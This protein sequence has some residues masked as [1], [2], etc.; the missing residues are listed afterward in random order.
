[1]LTNLLGE[2]GAPGEA[3]R[4]IVA[5]AGG[6]PLFIEEMLRMLVD[7][8]HLVRE[9]EAWVVRGDL[10]H[11]GAP[12]T[13][14]AVIAARLDRLDP[15]ERAVLQ[16]ASVVG[17]VFWWGAV[18]DLSDQ[19][20]A[21]QV[22]RSLQALVRKEL[23]RPGPSTFAG[24]DAFRFGHL[25]IR[26]V[27][28]ESIPK[29]VRADLHARFAAWVEQRAGERAVEYEEI[30]GYHAEQ[31]H[32][33]LSELGPLDDRGA[34]LAVLA[35]ERLASAGRRSF[36]RGDM[37]AAG[38]LLARAASLLPPLHQT[39]LALLH[40]LAVALEETGPLERAEATLTEALESGRAAGDKSL[41]L[42]AATRLIYVWL[43][44]SPA[45]THEKALAELDSIIAKL[46]E[47]RDDRATAEALLVLGIV[48]FWGGRC[49]EALRTFQRA[50]EHAGRVGDRRSERELKHWMGLTLVQGLTPAEEA[51][52]RIRELLRGF[53]D[54][55]IFRG[56]NCRFLS[57]LEG[58]QGN[59]SKAWSL[60][61][62][63]MEIARELGL[64]REAGGLQ[65]SGGYVALLSGDLQRAEEE[66][67]SAVAT[68]K[69]IGDT[70]HLVSA[71][72]DLGLVLLES[73][74]RELEAMSMAK[75][76]EEWLIEDD[77]DAQVRW[78]AVK[79]RALVRLGEADEAERLARHA[80]AIAGAT[81]YWNLRAISHEAMAEVLHRTG[82]TSEAAE[83][84]RNAIAVYEEKRNLVSAASARNALAE[85]TAGTNAPQA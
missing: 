39:R 74:G 63:G 12:E 69:Q 47:L 32:R 68:L 46:E 33:Y 52:I 35:G 70:G 7:D 11:I 77:V 31:A 38:H 24:E 28:Y 59:F 62:E 27:A 8:G 20:E 37:P 75:S 22:G 64:V 30:V 85:L 76:A 41:E 44:R 23:I 81:E 26:D 73:P 34:A 42:L 21:V 66:L 65:R 18:G 72:A 67:R 13:V 71:A 78:A 36:D 10:A 57:E 5:A 45:A 49:E 83:A 17:E 84:L 55:R 50:A 48:H 82:R 60:I 6:N 19:G 56:S 61:A 58:M 80:V 29:K 53:E 25:L 79:A 15:S 51:I 16:Q 43:I 14:Q 2:A 3:E 1:M 54:D 40:P 9:R 4:Q